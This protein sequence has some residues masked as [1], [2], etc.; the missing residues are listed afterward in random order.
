MY[1]DTYNKSAL[2]RGTM[3]LARA[4]LLIFV[5]SLILILFINV[6]IKHGQTSFLNLF[7]FSTT[8]AISAIPAALPVVTTFCL[9]KGAMALQKHKIIIKRLSVI[10]DFGSVE[11]LCTD[12][13][14]TLTE[15]VLTINDISAKDK[16]Q[17][18]VYA[19][20]S[21]DAFMD[22]HKTVL[23]SF[24]HAIEQKLTQN[25]KKEVEQYTIIHSLPFTYEKHR[26]ISLVK[27]NDVYTLITKGSAE[28][29]IKQCSLLDNDQLSSANQ[30]IQEHETQGNRVIAVATKTIHNSE[31]TNNFL[32]NEDHQYESLGL[33]A[34]AD[35]LKTTA[36]NAIKKAQA[37][38]VRIKILSGDSPYI[39]YSIAHQLGLE[40]DMKNVV[41]GSDFENSTEEQKKDLAY[42][43]T[44]FARVTPEQKYQIINYLQNSYSVSY[45]G[46]GVNDAPA[47][48]SAHVG[49]AVNDA[50]PIAREA[51]DII[52]L[53]KSL[54]NI[55]LGIEEGRKIIIN[56]L[57]Y[58][59]I[60]IAS[61]VGI[62]YSL[63]LSSLFI[64]YLPMLPLQLLFLD[65]ITDFPLIAIATDAVNKK[66]LKK[67]VHYDIKDISIAILLFG[68]ICLPFDFLIFILFKADQQTLHTCWFIESA[69]KQLVLIFSL[70]TTLPFWKAQ[71]PSLI[72]IALCLIAAFIV[73]ALPFSS[74]GQSIFH[75]A[76]PTTHNLAIIFAVIIGY[77]VVTE[78]IKLLYYKPLKNHFHH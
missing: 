49:I 75:F 60:T 71:R 26:S 2:F 7:L 61:N 44:I 1:I 68:F 8:L 31:A 47:L 45:V 28:Y 37:L 48:H 30:W 5:T 9:T 78:I 74:L 3:Q 76:A 59:K 46:D 56:T 66:D 17:T 35:P 16:E 34:F 70:R 77:F 41:L 27:K 10:E 15:N 11:I 53:Q 29:V 43:R 51:A 42:K 13:T 25:N 6:A 69:L 36:I 63:A 55:I 62:F 14:G 20:V 23:Q 12:K 67:P 65:L 32:E 18:L 38:N 4:V 54:Y 72:L 19:A 33:I 73:V 24:D 52:L 58:I 40:N 21:S 22:S 50:S 64:D 39:C 57:K